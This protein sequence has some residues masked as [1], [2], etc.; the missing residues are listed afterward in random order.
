LA[1]LLEDAKDSDAI[2]MQHRITPHLAG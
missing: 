2:N 1:K